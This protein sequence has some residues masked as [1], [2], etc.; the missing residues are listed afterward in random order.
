MIQTDQTCFTVTLTLFTT[1]A[2]EVMMV[3]FH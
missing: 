2:A 1:R 3:E